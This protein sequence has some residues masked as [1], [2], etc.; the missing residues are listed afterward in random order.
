MK[1][2]Q[3]ILELMLT[4]GRIDLVS[5]MNAPEG[6]TQTLYVLLNFCKSHDF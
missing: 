6:E 1:I 3:L 5:F 2:R 4:Q